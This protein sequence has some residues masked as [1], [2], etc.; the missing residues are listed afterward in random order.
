MASLVAFASLYRRRAA[1]CKRAYTCPDRDAPRPDGQVFAFTVI[2][3]EVKQSGLLLQLG[4]P[5]PDRFAAM[6]LA[7]TG[8]ARGSHATSRSGCAILSA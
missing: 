5:S 6:L 2:A 1:D 7:M 4:G 8:G 3:N